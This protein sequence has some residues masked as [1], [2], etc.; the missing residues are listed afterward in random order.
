MQYT[1]CYY[2]LC[3]HIHQLAIHGLCNCALL[4]FDEVELYSTCSILSATLIPI[5]FYL[6]HTCINIIVVTT[7]Y[8][9]T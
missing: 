4:I 1:H 6:G 8:C 5:D 3:T 9:A 7:N 2:M